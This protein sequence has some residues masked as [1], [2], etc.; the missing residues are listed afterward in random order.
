MAVPSSGNW[1]SQSYFYLLSYFLQEF[2]MTACHAL[3]NWLALISLSLGGTADGGKGHAGA[4]LKAVRVMYLNK[5]PFLKKNN[6]KK[7]NHTCHL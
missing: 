6:H 1:D 4:L 2:Y 5:F 3:P 7:F